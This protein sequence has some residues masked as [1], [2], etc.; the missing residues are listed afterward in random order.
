MSC[1]PI[2]T[3][4]PIVVCIN[5]NNNKERARFARSLLAPVSKHIAYFTQP[6]ALIHIKCTSY[7]WKCACSV[8]EQEKVVQAINSLLTRTSWQTVQSAS[9]ETRYSCGSFARKISRHKTPTTES[10]TYGKHTWTIWNP[11]SRLFVVFRLPPA[12]VDLH[13]VPYVS[14]VHGLV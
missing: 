14:R 6:V 3:A 4:A 11:R 9:Q 13:F 2:P 10:P 7:S 8:N 5:N 12:F 1:Y